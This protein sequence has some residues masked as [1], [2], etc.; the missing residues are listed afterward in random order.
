MLDLFALP[1]PNTNFH[2]Q[3]IHNR[4]WMF[5]GQVPTLVALQGS[6]PG[7]SCMAESETATGWMSASAH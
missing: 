7:G 5:W 1:R 6:T 3:V 2:T 4:L